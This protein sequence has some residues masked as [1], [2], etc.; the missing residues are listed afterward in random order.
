M[1]N[2]QLLVVG[3]RRVPPVNS[4]IP[5]SISTIS[6]S[7][8]V[9]FS[10]LSNARFIEIVRQTRPDVVVG[11][12]DITLGR[13]PG[14]R[15]LD[16]MFTRTEKW[17][18]DLIE[19]TT[20]SKD[21][22]GLN[23]PAIFAPIL[24][25]SLE[26]QR[27]YLDL[28]EDDLRNKLS[29]LAIYDSPT[30]VDLPESLQSLPRLTLT[31]PG[32]PHDT[33]REVSLGADLLTM[34]F[35]NDATDAGIALDFE[36]TP[37]TEQTHMTAQK[38]LGHDMWFSEFSTSLDP[39][40]KECKCYACSK[41][42]RAY[43]HHLLSAKEMLAWVLIQ[44]HNLEVVSVFFSRI[45]MSIKEGTFEQDRVDFG[46]RYEPSLPAKTGRGPR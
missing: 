25:V 6:I 24:P 4:P 43:I 40:T 27:W 45:H 30:L 17:T 41:H 8:S 21:M 29:G 36:F 39:I 13:K 26:Q 12:G 3:A 31:N 2:E 14:Q 28:L 11:L 23:E 22:N 18:K 42:H 38:P 33:I 7:T 44:I 15:K 34:S 35:I 46:R 5:N 1:P 16:K 9:G 37:S 20:I 19:A 10:H 32:S